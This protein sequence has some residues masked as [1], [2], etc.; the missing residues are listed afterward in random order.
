M[1]TRL[2][3]ILAAVV[4]LSMVVSACAPKAAPTPTKPPEEAKPI[5][6]VV[7]G[8]SVHPYW[9]NVEKGTVAAAKDLG[10]EAIF[11]VPPKED[12]AA[13][14]QTMETYIAQGG[15]GNG[16]ATSGPDPPEPGDEKGGG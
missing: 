15:T 3:T 10:V 14:I 5:K 12:V 9:S 2:F 1:K 4:V 13:Q 16:Q 7:I 6:I 8:K 11:F